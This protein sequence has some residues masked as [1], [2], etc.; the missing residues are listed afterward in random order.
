MTGRALVIDDATV[1]DDGAPRVIRLEMPEVDGERVVYRW[2][3]PT[4][5]PWQLRHSFEVV[6]PGLPMKAY[7]KEF[8]VDIF[9]SLQWPVFSL[10][11]G[12]VRIDLPVRMP[13]TSIEWWQG[14]HAAP[15]VDAGPLMEG[16]YSA[17]SAHPVV[18]APRSIAAF[19]GAGKDSTLARSLLAEIHGEDQLLL[20]QMVHPFTRSPE[21][22]DQLRT[23]QRQLMIDPVLAGSRLDAQMIETDYLANLTKAGMAA[24]PHTNLY[25]LTSLPVL[26]SR[27][28][29]SASMSNERTAYWLRRRPDGGKTVGYARSRPEVY[30]ALSEHLAEV[31]DISIS[32][33]NT[34]FPISEF[35]SYKILQERYPAAFKKIVMCVAAG[36]DRR[37]CMNC[38]KC[39]QYVHFGLLC[40]LRH[41]DV[42]YDGFW[43][44]SKYIMK[45]LA[46][47]ESGARSVPPGHNHPWHADV[48]HSYHFASFCHTMA[49]LRDLASGLPARARPL[50]DRLTAAWGNRTFDSIEVVST[51]AVD[52]VGTDMLRSI[53]AIFAQH[54]PVRAGAFR[55]LP[56]MN[57]AVDYDFSRKTDQFGRFV[58]S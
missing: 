1:L 13:R 49:L 27:G 18:S 47:A 14:F 22:R 55:N 32:F 29:R 26:L 30:A 24:R 9:L 44:T 38:K 34:H 56:Y 3:E 6:Y 40:G 35:L 41:P 7:S 10:Y 15:N 19:F 43:A 2:S 42:D 54:A 33:G 17:W 12:R 5:S 31:A 11:P 25:V 48:S 8:L 23:R 50:I 45:A 57:L 4:Q 52:L 16:G 46:H 28:V 39:A 20:V 58:A 51:D 36:P 53:A 21:S 37:W